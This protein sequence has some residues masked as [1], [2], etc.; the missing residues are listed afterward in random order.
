MKSLSRVRKRK[1]RC[2]ELAFKVMLK[3]PGAEQ[4]TLIHGRLTRAL[5]GAY[6]TCMDRDQ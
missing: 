4:F 3:E 2:Y 1:G 6:F 5:D